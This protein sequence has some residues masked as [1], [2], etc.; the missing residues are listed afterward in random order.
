M[1]RDRSRVD[2][3]ANRLSR[4]WEDSCESLES[5]LSMLREVR[6]EYGDKKT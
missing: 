4:D 1:R 6:A 5:M 3:I 2:E